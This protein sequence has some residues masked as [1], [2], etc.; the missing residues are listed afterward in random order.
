MRS[1]RPADET[2]AARLSPHAFVFVSGNH[3]RDD[4]RDRRMNE[5]RH[6]ADED[7]GPDGGRR[8]RDIRSAEAS[9]RGM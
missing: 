5:S 1:M 3:V 4:D 8:Q 2:R 9:R 6:S 7:D